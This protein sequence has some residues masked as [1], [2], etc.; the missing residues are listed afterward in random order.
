MPR[1]VGGVAVDQLD[2]DLVEPAHDPAALEHR[3]RVGDDL[4]ELARR[5]RARARR[6]GACAAARPA[7]ATPAQMAPRSRSSTSAGAARA[8]PSNSSSS[9][10]SPWGS[11]SCHGA[12][13]ALG[14]VAQGD[15]GRGQAQVGRVV[16]GRR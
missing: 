3:D 2:L 10:S 16:V 8:T 4:G 1:Q 13:A 14:A 7:R 6:C 5:R 15:P 11:F 12:A 9:R